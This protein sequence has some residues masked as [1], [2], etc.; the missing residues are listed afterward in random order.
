MRRIPYFAA[1][2]LLAII[3]ALL[4]CKPPEQAAELSVNAAPANKPV[5]IPQITGATGDWAK[6]AHQVL[7]LNPLDNTPGTNAELALA[8]TPTALLL[9]VRTDDATP[10]EAG[11]ELWN[12]DSIEL[13]M[14]SSFGSDD[15]LQMIFAPGRTPGQPKPRWHVYDRPMGA[16]TLVAPE[17]LTQAEDK[18]YVMTLS[19]PWADLNHV[20]KPGDVIGLQVLVNDARGHGLVVERTWFPDRLAG[21]DPL[22]MQRVQLA[23]QADP[24]Q[25]ATARIR[26]DGFNGFAVEVLAVPEAAGKTVEIWSGG[27]QVISGQLTAGGFEG[28]SATK[29]ALPADLSAQKDAP[30]I[31]TVDGQLMPTNLKIPDLAATQLALL[32]DQ[33]LVANP[34]IFD[35]AAF[36]KIDFLYKDLIEA[37][38]GSYTLHTRFFDANWN[39]VTTADTPGRYGALIEF[40]AQNGLTFTRNLTLFKTPH[41][42]V[43]STDPYGASVTFPAAFGLPT[44]IASREQ[45]VISNAVGGT[46]KNQ[47]SREADGATLVAALHDI[48]TDPARYHGFNAWKIDDDWWAELHKRL[49]ADQEYGHLTYLP[50]GY[51]KD[52][53]KVA[54]DPLFT[55]QRKPRQ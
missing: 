2:A 24:A 35:G 50:D 16:P 34:S 5:Q 12:G 27:K 53:K 44:D 41:S 20:P 32:K 30:L 43:Q 10:I 29:I 42:Y 54:H 17:M 6:Q 36:P 18:G 1:G 46:L 21:G 8:W 52:Q 23:T 48:Q 47:I 37:V 55:W 26:P 14:D 19:V 33:P 45:W 49:G 13:F 9:Q 7:I 38:I 11:D 39:E 51:D 3:L 40:R 4:S 25:V 22:H 31:V 15:H 28:D